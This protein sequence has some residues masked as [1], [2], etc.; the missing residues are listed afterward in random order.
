VAYDKD[1]AD[2]S[3]ELVAGKAGL[4]KQ[5]V[6]GGLALS[7]RPQTWRLRQAAKVAFDPS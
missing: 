7:D 5:K 4:T 3:R 2:R 1:L 6:S